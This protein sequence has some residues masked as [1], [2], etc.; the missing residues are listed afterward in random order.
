MKRSCMTALAI[1]AVTLLLAAT[2]TA[3]GEYRHEGER[4]SGKSMGSKTMEPMSLSMMAPSLNADQVRELQRL[5][6]ERGYQ[7]GMA[8]G[9]IGQQ[10]RAAIHR[11]QT[12]NGLTAN[13]IP[14]TQTLRALAP[15]AEQQEFFGLAPAEG[16]MN[17]MMEQS[18]EKMMGT[19]PGEMME[20]EPMKKGY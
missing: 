11:F 14:D 4:M 1:L 19:E 10:T 6:T 15:H 2:A 18:Q 16:E 17:E 8:D 9:I 7:P 20:K 5:L 13:G 12:D 3:S